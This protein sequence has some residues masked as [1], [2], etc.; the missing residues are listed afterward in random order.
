LADRLWV[1]ESCRGTSCSRKLP[2]AVRHHGDTR[3]GSQ[4]RDD[5]NQFGAARMNVMATPKRSE[6][7]PVGLNTVRPY[8]IVGDANTAIDFYCEVFGALE[9]ERHETPSGGVGHAKLCIGDAIVEIGEHPDA[10]NRVA[11]AIPSVGLRLYVSDVN[12]THARAIAAGGSGD[13]PTERLPGTR[14]ATV[15]DPFGLTWWLAEPI[16]P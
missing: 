9:I 12:Q 6:Y 3:Q 13:P 8:L 10:A 5:G 1:R 16:G 7:E 15:T 4:N 14:S 11:P 2:A